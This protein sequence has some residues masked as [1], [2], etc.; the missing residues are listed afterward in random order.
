M[1][2]RILLV[3]L[4]SVLIISLISLGS[5]I[6]IKTQKNDF[7]KLET[8]QA[9]IT[10]NILE[11]IDKEDVG[12]YRDH[13]QIPLTYDV[14]K[15]NNTYYIFAI[16][17]ITERNYSVKISQLN[18]RENNQVKTED[19]EKV[20]NVINETAPFNFFPGFVITN[21]DFKIKLSNNL[22]S[23]T[24]ISYTFENTSSSINL[25]ASENKDLTISIKNIKQTSVKTLT[26]SQGDYNYDI[27]T[28]II[29]NES[30][31]T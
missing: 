13:V 11:N 30:D 15:F 1:K 6:E 27:F 12:F 28:Y 2:K 14:I 31:T 9:T 8:F 29:P 20:F 10:G 17:P 22:D 3:L 16:L 23:P 25:D 7:S 18:Y 24:T 5:A 19:V 21:Q 26:L 4:L